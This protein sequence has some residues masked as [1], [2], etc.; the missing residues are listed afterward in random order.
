MD[1]VETSAY[2]Q[3]FLWT[4]WISLESFG[5][6]RVVLEGLVLMKPSPSIL[7]IKMDHSWVLWKIG[8]RK[9]DA[10]VWL[11]QPLK[12]SKIILI[13][14]IIC[15]KI[16]LLAKCITRFLKKCIL[17]RQ[18]SL[19]TATPFCREI[20]QRNFGRDQNPIGGEG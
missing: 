19:A 1:T 18:A 16:L 7:S 14:E 20:Q 2:P 4:L 8:P 10:V 6:I 9:T 15:R 11:D 5:V 17:N 12:L 3:K 13:L